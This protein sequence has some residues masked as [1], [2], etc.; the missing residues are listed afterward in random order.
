MTPSIR[1]RNTIL[2]VLAVIFLLAAFLRIHRLDNQ[3]FWNDE[4]N[5]ARLS[6]R[7]PRLIIE[8][9]AS[10]VHPPLY[11]LMLRGWRELAGDT[12]FGLRSLSTFFG[13]GI[14]ALTFAFGRQLLGKS[15]IPAAVIGTFLAAINPALIYYSQE[16]RMYELLTYLA[17]L[18]TVLLLR[19][20][21]KEQSEPIIAIAY[22]VVATAGLYT[23]YF[24][25]VVLFTQLV[26]ILGWFL[27]RRR[28]SRIDSQVDRP[29]NAL[30]ISSAGGK[31]GNWR[32][33]LEDLWKPAVVVG[34]PFILYLPW[35]PIFIR[36]IGGRS[37]S[38]P[39]PG[40]F[41]VDTFSW[42]TF[43]PTFELDK[44]L[45][46]VVAYML[47]LMVAL[48]TGWIMTR[49]NVTVSLNLLLLAVIPLIMMWL[50][51]ATRPAYFKFLLV[52]VPPISM[53]A[54][55]GW[56]SGWRQLTK[57]LRTILVGVSWSLP[58]L[59]LL[60]G[61][62][63]AQYNMYYVPRFYRDDYRSIASLIENN[64]HGDVAVILN[65]ANQWEVFTYYYPD[66]ASVFPL[67]IGK[68]DPDTIDSQLSDIT[69]EHTRIYALF[70]GEG[71][72][73]PERLVESWLDENAF[74]TSEEWVGDV[75]LASY[76]SPVAGN[77][78]TVIRPELLFGDSIRLISVWL[79][80]LQAYAGD[81]LQLTLTW[82]T[83]APITKRYKVFIHLINDDQDIV[84][85][86]DSEPAGGMAPTHTWQ[87][88]IEIS[89]N[90]GL[91][92]PMELPVGRYELL[93]G[94]YDLEDPAI[95][96]PIK[97]ESPFGDAYSLGSIYVRKP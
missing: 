21:R 32:V 71:E 61:T 62:Y 42:V 74:K 82:Q 14:V 25:P 67:P 93:L 3:S 88:N 23:H 9:T 59:L 97:P 68:P 8:G 58:G 56:W 20:I 51:G 49:K 94:L 80:D 36:Q 30:V 12:E 47:L 33:W 38:R 81:I 15:R 64:D 48:V 66:G 50:L 39:G 54:G 41:L 13:I 26:V 29:E 35:I 75:R 95:R 11:Y 76:G 83:E 40:S 6:E 22:V 45:L 27:G 96:L 4:G 60:F 16:A 19:F 65:A 43:G 5:S 85:Q 24:F 46:P 77:Q 84:A 70:W 31:A 1:F 18:S 7:S 92:L 63:Q 52:I 57:R 10:D 17:L 72:R 34:I 55:V 37:A 78:A 86:R 89:D 91:L 53:L 69:R 28:R 44:G 87:P 73:D 2:P 79:S 90:H